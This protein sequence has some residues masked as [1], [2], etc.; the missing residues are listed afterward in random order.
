MSIICP[1]LESG[2]SLLSVAIDTNGE[3]QV[4]EQP[5]IAWQ[6][7]ETDG[8]GAP[9]GIPLTVGPVGLHWAVI[10]KDSGR[11]WGRRRYPDR[12]AA[13][14]DLLSLARLALSRED[15]PELH[16]TPVHDPG[17][18]SELTRFLDRIGETDPAIRA[19]FLARARARQAGERTPPAAQIGFDDLSGF[20]AAL[21]IEDQTL[22]RDLL[23]ANHWHPEAVRDAFI[24]AVHQAID[25]AA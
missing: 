19:D 5:I 4:A 2:L 17:T 6:F 21:G 12:D 16:N 1:N 22:E 7:H 8:I 3:L 14:H 13:E 18:D 25:A 11:A 23:N 20:I 24:R 15:V 9:E 10:D